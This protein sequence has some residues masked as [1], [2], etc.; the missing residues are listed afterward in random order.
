M[1]QHHE[2]MRQAAE[3]ARLTAQVQQAKDEAQFA[4]IRLNH[5]ANQK[6]YLQE[7]LKQIGDLAHDKSTGPAVPDTLW[8]IRQL[9][10]D[11]FKEN[12]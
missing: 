10:Y 6:K 4:L 3:I 7:V 12:F 5:E 8:E 2:H 9:A 11:A 1:N